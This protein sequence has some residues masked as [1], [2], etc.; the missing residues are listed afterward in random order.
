MLDTAQAIIKRVGKRMGLSDSD[1]Q[2]LLRSDAIH[3]F[4]IALSSGKK[5]SAYRVQHNNTL[6]PYKGGIRF[7]PAVILG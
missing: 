5:H 7:H 4:E 3:E 1:I 6:G 2:R